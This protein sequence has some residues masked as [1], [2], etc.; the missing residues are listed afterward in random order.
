M[1]KY[2]GI[3][4]G[5]SITA[6]STVSEGPT[7]IAFI[8]SDGTA[9]GLTVVLDCATADNSSP[10]TVATNSYVGLVRLF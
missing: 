7:T 3:T 5:F 10:M 6:N 4:V 9:N 1:I 2:K 8:Q